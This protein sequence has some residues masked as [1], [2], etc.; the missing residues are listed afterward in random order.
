MGCE[1]HDLGILRDEPRLV[2]GALSAAAHDCDLLVTSGGMSVGREDHIRSIIGRRGTLDVWPLAIKPG[3]PV[4]LGDIDACPILALPGN[5][6]A[7][8]VTFIAFGRS[9]VDQLAGAVDQ[10]PASLVFHAGFTF[11]KKKGARQYLL[12]N[13][14]K[15]KQRREHGYANRQTGRGDALHHGGNERLHRASRGLRAR[16]PGRRGGV[17]APELVLG[18]KR[19]TSL[20][21]PHIL[22]A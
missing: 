4:G 6:I 1:V 19:L 10:S 3:R 21:E 9:V 12:A 20:L 22:V 17:R 18:L 15:G 16:P 11:E 8:V 14:E 2:E 5:P 7:A 13:I